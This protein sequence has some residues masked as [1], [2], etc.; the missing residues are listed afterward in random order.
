MQIRKSFP[1]AVLDDDA[2]L[3]ARGDCEWSGAVAVPLCNTQGKTVA[4]PHVLAWPQRLSAQQMRRNFL[5]LLL[6]AA[7]AFR[8]LL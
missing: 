6:D 1:A 3:V 5:P 7:R 8:S 2:L 4:A